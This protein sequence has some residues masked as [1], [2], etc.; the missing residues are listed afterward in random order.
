[1]SSPL[2]RPERAAAVNDA[3]PRSRAAAWLSAVRV[4]QWPKNLLVIAAPA[5]AGV[6]LH[7]GILGDVASAFVVF[8]LLS[9]GV[10][11]LNDV[12]DAPDDRRHPTKR[13]RAVASGAIPA[14]TAT[15]AGVALAA[16]GIGLSFAAG[17]PLAA[18]GTGY[19]ALNAAYTGWLRR[20]AVA[21]IAVIA[22]AFL[23]R[24][25][26]GGLAAGVPISRWFIVVVSFSALLVA[27]G[28]R[29]ADLVDLAARRSRPVLDEYT[30]EFLRLVL[31][32]AC[33]VA[34]GA[35]CLWAFEARHPHQPPWRELTIVPFTLALLRYGL[36]VSKGA[37]SAP[38]D[39]LLRDRFMA[40]MGASWLALFAASL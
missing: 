2:E 8:C 26:A 19:L 4:R 1:V 17:W 24:A 25:A 16:A 38:E 34:V 37:G 35:Y 10:Y 12:H 40:V 36:L 28:K 22:I 20:V 29:L 15:A 11:L 7:E 27:A 23:L 21:D 9:S 31:S 5:A 39:I 33:A 6:L 30:P 18:A 3:R 13:R 32:V 14:A